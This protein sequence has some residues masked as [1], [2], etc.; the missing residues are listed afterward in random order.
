[1]KQ[2]RIN[3]FGKENKGFDGFKKVIKKPSFFLSQNKFFIFGKSWK[4]K[5]FKKKSGFVVFRMRLWGN[6]YYEASCIIL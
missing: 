6:V 4:T 5:E 2:I 3:F 1:M